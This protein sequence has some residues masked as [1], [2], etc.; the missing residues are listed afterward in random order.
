MSKLYPLLKNG[1]QGVTLSDADLRSIALWLDL[2]SD[3]F[4]DDIKRDAQ[5][6]GDAVTPSIE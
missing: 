4:S 3:M 2:N 1:H 5:A 6:N